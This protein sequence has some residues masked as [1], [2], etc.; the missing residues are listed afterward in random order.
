MKLFLRKNSREN[1]HLFRMNKT[2]LSIYKK[3]LHQVCEKFDRVEELIKEKI[4]EICCQEKLSVE[5]ELISFMK[6][7]VLLLGF[8]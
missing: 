3:V 6:D 8:K 4:A 5:R 1:K 7:C 2:K